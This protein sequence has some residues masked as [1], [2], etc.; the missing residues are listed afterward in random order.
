[1]DKQ[2]SYLAD[3]EAEKFQKLLKLFRIL[4]TGNK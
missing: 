1:M 4:N 2:A 3:I